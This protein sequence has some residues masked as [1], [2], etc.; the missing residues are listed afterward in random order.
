MHINNLLKVIALYI[1]ILLIF[2]IGYAADNIQ[3][4]REPLKVD[5]TTLL[6]TTVDTT[7]K[8]SFYLQI[9]GP[10]FEG[11]ELFISGEKTPFTLEIPSGNFMGA[12]HTT[13]K[14][15]KLYVKIEEFYKGNRV[16]SADSKGSQLRIGR[17]DNWAGVAII[18]K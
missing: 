10:P 4:S 2:Q 16:L 1:S 15:A 18:H 3:K 13:E 17:R 6:I 8:V 12:I 14:G 5:K 9:Y 11:A 7:K